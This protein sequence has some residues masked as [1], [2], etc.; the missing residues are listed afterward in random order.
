VINDN[1]YTATDIEIGTTGSDIA[2]LISMIVE[3]K[4]NEIKPD[5]AYL[6]QLYNTIQKFY[7]N[8]HS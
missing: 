5:D 6:Y 3:I 2:G 4:H 7:K 8:K 1:F